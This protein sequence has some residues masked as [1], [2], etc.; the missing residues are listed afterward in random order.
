MPTTATSSPLAYEQHGT[1]TPIVFLHGLT[2][3][4]TSWRPVIDR[5]GDDVHSIAIDLPAHGDS[6]GPPRRLDEVAAQ[7]HELLDQLGIDRP[8][9]VGHSMSGSIAMIYAAAYPTRGA[10]SVDA[11]FDLRPFATLVKQLEPAL[12]GPGFAEAFAPFQQSMRLDLVR[13]PLPQEIR[14]DV[15]VGYW[16]ELMRMDAAEAQR[17]V[18]QAAAAINVPCLALFGRRLSS[19]ERDHIG[20]LVPTAAVE[21]WD[22]DGHCLHL[23]E[24]DRFAARLRHFVEECGS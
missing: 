12:R 20:A 4:R 1:G 9:V 22:G 5:L 2:F 11:P 8:I 7:V 24:V 6:A 13:E 14:Q 18:E 21:E 19:P 10:V 15:V 16:E 23:V 17:W 3:D